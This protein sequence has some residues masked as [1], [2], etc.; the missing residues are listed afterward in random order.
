[1]NDNGIDFSEI[2]SQI[3]MDDLS[4]MI[5]NLS[6]N[7]NNA[8]PQNNNGVNDSPVVDVD[9]NQSNDNAEDVLDLLRGIKHY[10]T[11]DRSKV[12]DDIIQ[13]YLD[14]RK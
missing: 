6:N 11:P 4:N 9:Y 8:N 7:M 3:N 13:N 5:N 10:L 1:M 2:F 14:S 12:L